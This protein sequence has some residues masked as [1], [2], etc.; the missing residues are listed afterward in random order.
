MNKIFD[1]ELVLRNTIDYDDNIISLKVP[2]CT[3]IK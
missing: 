1:G 3:D 2:N